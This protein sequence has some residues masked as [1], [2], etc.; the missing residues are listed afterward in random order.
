MRGCFIAVTHEP[1]R[2]GGPDDRLQPRQ[3]RHRARD[4]RGCRGVRGE[5]ALGEAFDRLRGLVRDDDE[6]KGLSRSQG[7]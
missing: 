2:W 1:C 5:K 3:D 6:R 7:E 4:L